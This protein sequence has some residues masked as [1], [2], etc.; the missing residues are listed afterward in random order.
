MQFGRCLAIFMMLVL[1]VLASACD[2]NDDDSKDDDSRIIRPLLGVNSGPGAFQPVEGYPDV[3]TQY[4]KIGVESVRFHDYY[5]ANDIMCYFPDENA[6]PLLDES[7]D[8]TETDQEYQKILDGGFAPMIRLGQGWRNMTSWGPYDGKPTGYLKNGCEFWKTPGSLSRTALRSGP[9]IFSKLLAH[10]NDQS[11]WGKAPIDGAYVEIWNEANILAINTKIPQCQCDSE[12][13]CGY[14]RPNYEWDGTP[15]EFSQFFAAT[16]KRLKADYPE[17]KIGGPGLHNM[18]C[19]AGN[20][21]P[22]QNQIGRKWTRNFLAYMQANDVPLDFFSWHLYDSNPANFKECYDN[23]NEDL[24]TY[25]YGDI[26]HLVTEYNTTFSAGNIGSL[27]G[28]A[29]VTGIWISLQKDMPKVTRA[30]LYR[31]NDGPFVPDGDGFPICY[32]PTSGPSPTPPAFGTSGVGL[33]DRGGESKPIALAF[34]FWA[35]MAGRQQVGVDTYLD[36][37]S[38]S[39]V[40]SLAGYSSGGGSGGLNVLISSLPPA[41]GSSGEVNFDAAAL[42]QKYGFELIEVQAIDQLGDTPSTVSL[43]PSGILQVQDNTVYLLRFRD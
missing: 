9:D 34:S 14:D 29:E 5:G 42:A 20:L 32:D 17:M 43:D 13:T 21:T 25:G 18:G 30:F 3:T 23:V 7:Y 1:A 19:G 8:W 12:E 27:A 11:L 6:D 37:A 28:A 41:G 10:L 26:E 22:Y 38:N 31:G 16:A 24:E 15:E 33:F 40:Y 36:N 35:E 39:S 4:Q 2:S